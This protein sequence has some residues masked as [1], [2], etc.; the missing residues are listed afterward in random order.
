MSCT[1]FVVDDNKVFLIFS[2]INLMLMDNLFEFNN[3]VST[4]CQIISSSNRIV[5]VIPFA[6]KHRV[7]SYPNILG[8]TF[9]EHLFP[10]KNF[11]NRGTKSVPQ[12]IIGE[13]GN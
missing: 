4:R 13:L 6:P 2:E 12:I 11:G 9:G 10:K 8:N 5:E 1:L 7:T 3:G